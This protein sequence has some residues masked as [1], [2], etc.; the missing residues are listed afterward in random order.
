MDSVKSPSS[1]R[2]E[3]GPSC[4]IVRLSPSESGTAVVEQLVDALDSHCV[5]RLVIETSD[6]SDQ[7]IEQLNSLREHIAARGG[8]VKL[9]HRPEKTPPA[10]KGLKNRIKAQIPVYGNLDAA[11]LSHRFETR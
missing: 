10:P 1:L 11:I 9:V 8:S 2:I 5:N 3:R 7:L 4:L 6:F